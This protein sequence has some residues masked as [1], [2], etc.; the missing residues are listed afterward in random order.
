ME[1]TWNWRNRLSILSENLATSKLKTYQISQQKS[2][3]TRALSIDIALSGH[4]F[5]TRSIFVTVMGPEDNECSLSKKDGEHTKYC[6]WFQKSYFNDKGLHWSSFHWW[7][8]QVQKTKARC[9]LQ[10]CQLGNLISTCVCFFFNV[11]L[12]QSDKPKW[13][14]SMVMSNAIALWYLRN[15]SLRLLWLFMMKQNST[16][17]MG[18]ANIRCLTLIAWTQLTLITPQKV[19]GRFL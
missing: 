16:F 8:M 12:Y 14:G 15:I 5:P 10:L 17:N 1:E 18:S 11:R 2:I 13:N 4:W 3:H 6:Y 19:D 9:I 7:I